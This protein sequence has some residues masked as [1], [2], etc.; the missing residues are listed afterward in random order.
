MKCFSG[1]YALL[2]LLLLLLFYL[3][4]VLFIKRQICSLVC[5]LKEALSCLKKQINLTLL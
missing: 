1:V 4:N 2:L 3:L 5:K